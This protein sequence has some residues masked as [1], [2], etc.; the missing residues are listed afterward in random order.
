MLKVF[1]F[2]I[3]TILASPFCV[4]AQSASEILHEIERLQT[5]QRVLYVAAH[6]DDENTRLISWLTHA[7]KADVA[8]LSLTRGSGGQNLIG[9]EIGDALG[10]IR[11]NELLEARRID[12]AR[13]FFT[14]ARDFGYSKTATETMEKWNETEIL[15]DMV[16][17]IRTYR[18]D[19][20]ITRF[21]PVEN[22][23]RPT[24]GHHTA[25][26]QL[27]LKAFD[28]ANDP[29]A[30]PEQLKKLKCWKTHAIVWNT[31]TW[32]Y[33]SREKLEQVLKEENRSYSRIDVSD[34]LPVLGKAC[35]EIAA[36][37]RSMHKS[38]GFGSSPSFGEQ[39]EYL[40]WLKGEP[41][42]TPF[43][44]NVPGI[45]QSRSEYNKVK[46]DLES[47][48]G[49]FNPF[50]PKNSVS[51]LISVYSKFV[52]FQ[53]E[54]PRFEAERIAQLIQACMG[55]KIQ[56]GSQVRFVARG[57]SLLIKLEIRNPSSLPIEEMLLTLPDG[58][59]LT[60]GKLDAKSFYQNE[61]SMLIPPNAALTEPYWLQMEHSEAQYAHLNGLKRGETVVDETVG[62]IKLDV[63]IL[64]QWLNFTETIQHRY[65][66]PVKGEVKKPLGIL[67]RAS[68]STE[69]PVYVAK[70]E[71]ISVKLS[72]VA[73][74]DI[75]NGYVEISLPEGW[76][77]EPKFHAVKQLKKGQTYY[78]SYVLNTKII[79]ANGELKAMLKEDLLITTSQTHEIN[80]DHIP[81][82]YW[83]EVSKAHL[84]ATPV[85][86][87]SKKVAY[88]EGAGDNVADAL[89]QLGCKVDRISQSNIG[90]VNFTNSGYDAVVLGVRAY[91]TIPDIES[92]LPKLYAFAKSGGIVIVQYNTTA[93]LKTKMSGPLN[94][95]VGRGRTTKENSPV[96][97]NLID[98]PVLTQPN[99]LIQSDFDGWV[100]ERGLYYA[101]TWDPAYQAPLSFSDPGEKPESGSLL[102]LPHE[103]GYF[104][105]TGISFFRQLPA[106]VPGAYRLMAN[107]LSLGKP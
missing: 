33:G 3:L 61:F 100:Q 37:S 46:E 45:Y 20:I 42:G 57:D 80:Y 52:T 86:C 47:I 6:P 73:H 41:L 67:P 70:P 14:R 76:V 10:I 99:A 11:T 75:P 62:V 4:K 72:L 95:T 29:K 103:K 8:Y 27:A 48:A 92:L 30:Y 96:L 38:Q 91:N 71:G 90:A 84:I 51:D 98:H 25:S 83:F 21:S 64:N 107:M 68:L 85:M 54:E 59:K 40:E 18:P 53:S 28:L 9:A 34:Y 88:V 49:R 2:F 32:F 97:F 35:T 66:D 7:Q 1:R 36:A 102:I 104:I 31:S 12:G 74:T 89:E 44:S 13:Q 65:T 69:F 93:N 24:H 82:H 19:L 105:Y 16:W 17:V 106:G 43:M 79:A 78:F 22:P 5:G 81:S 23:E 60:I 94:Y 55:L 56:A 26:A 15:E 101:S 63:K 77:S 87:K 39:F 50:Q 58:R